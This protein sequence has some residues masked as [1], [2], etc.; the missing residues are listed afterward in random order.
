MTGCIKSIS[1]TVY[2]N[3][4]V[5]CVV[6]RTVVTRS[7][8][9]TKSAC[10]LNPNTGNKFTVFIKI[11]GFCAGTYRLNCSKG[12]WAEVIIIIFY[13]LPTAYKL[14]VNC[15]VGLTV[16]FKQ[17]CAGVVF[18]AANGA[19]KLAV[20]I[21]KVMFNGWYFCSPCN[22]RVTNL[23]ICAAGVSCLFARRR[24]IFKGGYGMNVNSA[25]LSKVC[26]RCKV[27]LRFI[28][29]C[30]NTERFVRESA[31][32][33]CTIS[34]NILYFTIVNVNFKV[35][36][37]EVIVGVGPVGLLVESRIFNIIC[38]RDNANRE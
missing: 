24:L 30:R 5:G 20:T 37:P 17:S 29:F 35:L 9:I 8:V 4:L 33:I 32:C 15:I 21:F 14:T 7:V 10:F 2:F 36:R 23:T 16:H 12:R 28:H 25:M 31:Y 13:L 19:Y 26:C 27:V 34:V 18:I 11:E 1:N 6:C 38:K 22:N 3:K